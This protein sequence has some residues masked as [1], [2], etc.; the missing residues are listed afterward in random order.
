MS[1]RRAIVTLAIGGE[2]RRRWKHVCSPNWSRYAA[3]HGYDLIC[4]DEP[5]DSSERAQRRSPAWQ[6]CLVLS[7]PFSARYDRIVWMDSDILLNPHA[8]DVSEGVPGG[9]VG[10]VDEFAIP[11]PDLN[12]L[13]R[14]K[15]YARWRRLGVP[16][17]DNPTPQSYY[18]AYGFPSGFGHVVQTGVMVLSPTHHRDLLERTYR[19]HEDRGGSHWNFEMRPLSYELLAADVVHW[20][21]PAFNFVYGI[22]ESL[23]F[24]FLA[25][26]DDPAHRADCL[27][28]ARRDTHVLHFAGSTQHM[29]LAASLESEIEPRGS[30]NCRARAP[31]RADWRAR[32]PVALFIFNRPETTQLAFEAIRAARPSTLAVIA[33]GPRPGVS[34]DAADCAAARSVI[35]RVD[36][37]CE[38]RTL[39]SPVNMGLRSRIE[40]GLTW[41]FSQ[42]EEAIILEDGCVPDATFFPF[43]DQML[44]RYRSDR[45][46]LSVSGCSFQ[47]GRP[48]GAGSYYFSR[49]A[50]VRGWATWRRAWNLH[51]PHMADWPD[52]RAGGWLAARFGSSVARQYWDRIFETA[53]RSSGT[54]DCRWCYS[55]CRDGGLHVIPNVNL[56]TNYG[57][58]DDSTHMRQANRVFAFLPTSPIGF[59]LVHP[60]AVQPHREADDF[61][62]DILYSGNLRRAFERGHARA[63]ALRAARERVSE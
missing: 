5:L 8:P 32:A 61:T 24:P 35:E 3:R 53:Y 59:P 41:L 52:A 7:Q 49:H 56:V 55:C 60:D 45:R 15:H 9:K 39:I 37:P 33:D 44:D 42:Y 13:V 63:A 1:E 62:E 29:G 11:S 34:E 21:D 48:R 31:A 4:I 12:R 30:V 58:D 14:R 26:S 17:I 23:H 19:T 10:A 6:K 22:Y 38:V 57:F 25:E 20:I 36:W 27:R 2:F 50:H 54:W 16:F 46:V 43:C 18:T 40:S 28:E 47:C 51:D